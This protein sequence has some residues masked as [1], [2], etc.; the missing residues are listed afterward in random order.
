MKFSSIV[1][2]AL[3]FTAACGVSTA[4]DPSFAAAPAIQESEESA[5]STLEPA[6][7]QGALSLSTS[8]FDACHG[9]TTCPSNYSCDGVSSGPFECGVKQ[10]GVLCA[11][12]RFVASLQPQEVATTC[13]K[14]GGS[15]T[16]PDY[17]F[18]K[19]APTI[20]KKFCGYPD[21]IQPE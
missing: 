18:I 3:A 11:N 9:T 4:D 16:D 20:K 21:C 7:D 6:V 19:L 10:C 15:A 1:L 2:F 17:V 12:G 5:R 14:N 13:H 8:S